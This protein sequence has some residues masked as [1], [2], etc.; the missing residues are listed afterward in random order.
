MA[1]SSSSNIVSIQFSLLPHHPI[2]LSHLCSM[3]SFLL[4]LADTPWS[5]HSYPHHSAYPRLPQFPAT[6]WKALQ[7]SNSPTDT[8][9]LL[10]SA[11]L[12]WI[13]HNPV[14]L[15]W[16]QRRTPGQVHAFR[17]DSWYFKVCRAQLWTCICRDIFHSST[18]ELKTR[19]L[20][21]PDIL[22]GS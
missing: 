6:D 7:P 4:A 15:W 10:G 17:S 20:L 19:L 18:W 9:Y 11:A 21:L 3:F 5:L 14:L 1:C 16:T 12:W 13:V 2:T 22:S 8:S